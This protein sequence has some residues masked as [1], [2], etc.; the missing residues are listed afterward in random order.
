MLTVPLYFRFFKMW[1]LLSTC[2][3][4]LF[5]LRDADSFAEASQCRLR[6]AFNIKVLPRGCRLKKIILRSSGC[7][8]ECFSS[9]TSFSY[10]T[11]F[12]SSCSCCAPVQYKVRTLTFPCPG[13]RHTIRYS[14]ATKCAC[15]PCV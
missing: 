4:L 5:L 2:I 8:G 11:G 14:S 3:F 9:T 10:R 15:R 13:K 7:S 6:P 12:A 1:R